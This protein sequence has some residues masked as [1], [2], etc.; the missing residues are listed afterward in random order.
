MSVSPVASEVFFLSVVKIQFKLTA[1]V[2]VFEEH[3]GVY[4]VL[5]EREKHYQAEKEDVGEPCV[6]AVAV[7]V[8]P[9]REVDCGPVN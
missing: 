5:R 1:D 8:Q 9:E 2:L 7:D 3:A 6:A 4:Q